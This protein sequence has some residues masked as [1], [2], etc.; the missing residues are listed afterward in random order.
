MALIS[1]AA[2]VFAFSGSVQSPAPVQL[3]GPWSVRITQDTF[4]QEAVCE[5]WQ[6]DPSTGRYIIVN[7]NRHV[8][9]GKLRNPLAAQ[10]RVDGGT[11]HNAGYEMFGTAWHR[12]IDVNARRGEATV[13]DSVFKLGSSLAIRSELDEPVLTFDVSQYSEVLTKMRQAQCPNSEY[14]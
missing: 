14:D 8:R 7:E 13:N 11:L 1:I 4:T 2:A 9:I 12:G 6:G 10:Y 3:V 5:V